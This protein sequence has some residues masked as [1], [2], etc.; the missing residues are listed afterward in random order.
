MQLSPSQP[1]LNDDGPATCSSR[2]CA[3]PST[4]SSSQFADLHN[5]GLQILHAIPNGAVQVARVSLSTTTTGAAT[6]VSAEIMSTMSMQDDDT[7]PIQSVAASK[8]KFAVVNERGKVFFGACQSIQH[9]SAD[10]AG[11]VVKLNR[12]NLG[13]YSDCE[14]GFSNLCFNSLEQC[15]STRLMQ[16]ESLLLVD[17]DVPPQTRFEHELAAMACTA[18][19]ENTWVVAEWGDLTVWDTRAAEGKGLVTRMLSNRFGNGDCFYSVATID[20]SIVVGG[21]SRM[22]CRVDAKKWVG[23]F[24]LHFTSV[25]FLLT[26]HSPWTLHALPRL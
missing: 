12:A 22:A 24:S 25:P 19:G 2:L 17:G 13:I 16:R 20:D 10:E 18:F 11:V 6:G 8:T 14:A 9:K 21:A 1:V 4:S 3:I 26:F 5:N 23:V 15:L 7:L